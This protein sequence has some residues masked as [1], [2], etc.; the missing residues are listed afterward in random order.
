[1]FSP[2][3]TIP[4]GDPLPANITA[5][6]IEANDLGDVI[7]KGAKLVGEKKGSILKFFGVK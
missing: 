1:M 4:E 7:G 6:V 3:K 5:S 2:T